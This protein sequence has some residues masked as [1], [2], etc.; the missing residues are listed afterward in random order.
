MFKGKST[1]AGGNQRFFLICLS[2]DTLVNMYQTNFTLIQER[3][4]NLTEI[5]NMIPW[6]REVYI[7]MVVNL[8]EQEAK[9]AQQR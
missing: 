1:I 7:A 3:K 9:R 5:D 4:F 6:E 2:H 8:I